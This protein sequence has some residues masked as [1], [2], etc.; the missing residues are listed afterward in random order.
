MHTDLGS[1]LA[2][3]LSAFLL[4]MLL[5]SLCDVGVGDQAAEQRGDLRSDVHLLLEERGGRECERVWFHHLS[6]EKY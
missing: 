5:H 4:L 1:L 2:R 3:G 6:T